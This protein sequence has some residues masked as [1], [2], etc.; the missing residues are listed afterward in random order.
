M[1]LLARD[2]EEGKSTPLPDSHIITIA[3][4]GDIMMGSTYPSPILPPDNGQELFSAVK[5]ELINSDIAIGNLEGPLCDSGKPKKEIS[6]GRNYAFC[7]PTHYVKNLTDAGFD[8]LNLA[9]NHVGDF[10]TV[11]IKTTKFILDSAGIKYTGLRGDIADLIVKG[12][13]VLVVGFSPHRRTNNLLNISKAQKIIA[14]L[15]RKADI[16][17]VTFHG[18]NEGIGSL[19]TKDT[20][21]YFCD[22]PRGN[23]VKFSHA[24]IDSGADLVFGH[25][26]H[27]PRA[28]EIYKD[29]LIAY[30]L[31]NFCT[32]GRFWVEGENGFSLILKVNL[33]T[34]GNFI[35]GKIIPLYQEPPG[36]PM[37]D[38]A[39]RSIKLIKDL[40]QTDFPLTAPDISDEGV[41]TPSKQQISSIR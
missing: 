17:I 22:D 30:S 34:L 7:T 11:G 41:I 25:G 3:A 39:G 16:V 40:S 38:S 12:K 2:K 35:A 4:V 5:S 8:V 9:N 36:V 14:D 24:V 37:S 31:G 32:Y 19:H 21:E 10:D 15:K 1:F 33:D 26:P 29:K 28:L 27:V 6:D 23:V 13:R 20:F 18:G